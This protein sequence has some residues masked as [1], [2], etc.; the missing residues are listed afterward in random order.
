MLAKK[1]E[2]YRTK[3]GWET[4]DDVWHWWMDDGFVKGQISIDEHMEG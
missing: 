4:V 2:H 1:S 3:Y